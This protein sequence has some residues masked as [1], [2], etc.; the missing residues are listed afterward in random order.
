MS[1]VEVEAAPRIPALGRA[2]E[3]V[4]LWVDRLVSTAAVILLLVE[5][6]LLFAGVVFRY[7]L[8]KPLVWTDEL[9]AILFLWL[10]IL[11]AV[12]AVRRWRHMRM[13]T[14]VVRLGTRAQSIIADLGI[15]LIAAVLCLLLP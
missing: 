13:S 3:A 1:G 8:H 4:G 6:V 7:V 12:M 5:T 9:N 2:I 10:G 14:F 11:G 15:A